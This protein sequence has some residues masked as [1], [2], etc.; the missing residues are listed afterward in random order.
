V[1]AANSLSVWYHEGSSWSDSG[2][3]ERAGLGD[4]VSDEGSLDMGP[5]DC[6]CS[7]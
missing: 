4:N 3:I 1:A 5:G 6:R 7:V 2:M